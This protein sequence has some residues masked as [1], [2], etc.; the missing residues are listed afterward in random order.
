[1]TQRRRHKSDRSPL[2]SQQ[3]QQDNVEPGLTEEWEEAQPETDFEEANEAEAMSLAQARSSVDAS[4]EDVVQQRRRTIAR[5]R[6]RQTVAYPTLLDM[7]MRD[8]DA[9]FKEKVWEIVVQTGVDPE[10]P[11]F[12]LMVATGRLEALL[13]DRPKEL[14]ALFDAWEERLHDQYQE[15]IDQCDR[16]AKA[17]V[18]VQEKE[19]SVAV[20]NLV[21]RTAIEQVMRSFNAASVTG[22]ILLLLLSIALGSGVT[23][24]L[25]RWQQNLVKYTP[26]TH[27]L[28]Q[29]DVDALKWANSNQG[30]LAQQIMQWN[31]RGL[32]RSP[33]GRL[34]C[35]QQAAQLKVTF[36]VNG[37]PA[38]SG[39]CPLWVRPP[40]ER[41]FDG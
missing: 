16:I 22:G 20:N 39:F 11:A 2:R 38:T 23:Y 36:E 31:Q 29:A 12:L 6:Q 35:E 7:V 33:S 28:T 26:G 8:R 13:E 34:A 19:I 25:M 9:T 15:R 32:T 5:Y 18:K 41:K 27:Q 40:N 10:E 4:V 1:M 24:S 3:F 30:R 17:A 14:E 21:R 37:K